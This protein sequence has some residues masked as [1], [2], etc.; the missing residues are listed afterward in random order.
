[1]QSSSLSYLFLFLM[2]IIAVQ[3]LLFEDQLLTFCDAL[4]PDPLFDEDWTQVQGDDVAA[5]LDDIMILFEDETTFTGLFAEA[6]DEECS[7]S[8]SAEIKS[9]ER[10]NT[11]CASTGT[12]HSL[13][14]S[15]AETTDFDRANCPA[16]SIFISIWFICSSSDSQDTQPDGMGFVL[17]KSTRCMSKFLSFPFLAQTKNLEEA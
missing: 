3:A 17:L 8:P 10:R 13:P 14:I 16:S 1:M 15:V 4:E 5:N 11:M 2:L 6:S 9:L 12:V 7:L